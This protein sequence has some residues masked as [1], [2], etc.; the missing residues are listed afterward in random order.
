MVQ[1][2]STLGRSR[3]EVG[4]LG[5]CAKCLERRKESFAVS[6]KQKFVARLSVTVAVTI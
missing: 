3:S 1:A 4:E 5:S 6:A 2:Q